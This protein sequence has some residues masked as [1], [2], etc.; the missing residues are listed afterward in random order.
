[1]NV[2]TAAAA[3]LLLAATA[4]RSRSIGRWR[5]GEPG[6]RNVAVEP[7]LRLARVTFQFNCEQNVGENHG[8]P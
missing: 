3:V 8:L 1:M 4:P 2:P 7:D 6:I 5:I